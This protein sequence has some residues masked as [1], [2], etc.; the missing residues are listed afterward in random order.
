M[1]VESGDY[2]AFEVDEDGGVRVTPVR[3]KVKPLK[4]FLAD[5][6]GSRK[7][8]NQEIRS[9]IRQRAARKFKPR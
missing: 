6:A 1:A 4:G 3:A 8:D 5:V 9:A 7:L 2:L